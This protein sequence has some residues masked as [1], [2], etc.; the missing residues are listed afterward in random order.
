MLVLYWTS[1]R[2]NTS[3]LTHLFDSSAL[4]ILYQSSTNSVTPLLVSQTT[5]QRRTVNPRRHRTPARLSHRNTDR[6]LH[7]CRHLPT[8]PF[9]PHPTVPNHRLERTPESTT[10]PFVPSPRNVHPAFAFSAFKYAVSLEATAR[11][12]SASLFGH[13]SHTTGYHRSDL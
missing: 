11:C 8:T 3:S 1:P 9:T 4:A 2:I 7:H 5:A 6:T 10:F 12:T 13:S